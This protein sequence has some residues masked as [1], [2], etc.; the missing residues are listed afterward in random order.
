MARAILA[1]RDAGVEQLAQEPQQPVL[2]T[3]TSRWCS[4]GIE[5]RVPRNCE[6]RR[7]RSA[8]AGHRGR[9]P[10]QRT[11]RA[12]MKLGPP[13]ARARSTA[14]RHGLDGRRPRPCRRGSRRAPRTGRT[15]SVRRT[16]ASVDDGYSFAFWPSA[17]RR[18]VL[19]QEDRPGA[20]RI[21]AMLTDSC[22]AP[23][24]S[25]PSPNSADAHPV[26]PQLLERER[27]ADRDGER[28]AH[29]S[30]TWSGKPCAADARWSVPP[31]PR[32]V[33]VALPR[34]SA[35]IPA[36]ID[37][38][39]DEVA[40]V[41]VRGVGHVTLL[42]ERECRHPGRLLADVDVEMADVVIAVR[43]GSAPP[44]SGGS[45]A[46]CAAGRR[47]PRR[48]VGE[49][50][51]PPLRPCAGPVHGTG[52]GT[53][54]VCT[55]STMASRPGTKRAPAPG[56]T[57]GGA[58]GAPDP[59]DRRPKLAA[60]RFLDP[61]RDLARRS[62]PASTASWAIDQPAGP[63]RPTRRSCPC[64]AGC[65]LRRS[66]TSAVDA[67]RGERR[68]RRPAPWP[69]CATSARCVT[70]VPGAADR[71][72]PERHE[73]GVVA[74]EDF[75]AASST[76]RDARGTAPG[77]RNGSRPASRPWASAGVDGATTLS[78]GTCANHA[79]RLWLWCAPMRAARAALGADRSAAPTAARSSCSAAWRAWL[80]SWSMASV[81]KSMNMIS[82][83]GRR[84]ESAAPTAMP[85]D[86]GLADR[87]VP[88]AP[89]RSGRRG[90]W[91]PRTGPP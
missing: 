38:A 70:S 32:L 8:A 86:R 5:R 40:V 22:Q 62:R 31:L 39:R 54:R 52:A 33:P 87:R 81:M 17:S 18:V 74:V 78:P 79:S 63:G 73:R 51:R 46:S 28:P 82:T 91:W 29:D 80:T 34:I 76:G 6:A 67:L 60:C 45:G 15:R 69:P 24:S 21:A 64:R 11:V 53:R 66:M 90:P 3:P 65:R 89:A 2:R 1:G 16:A 36:R 4:S 88:D 9:L 50:L 37:A 43:G 23:S 47:A 59:D 13:P 84:P 83:I 44:R 72:A 26:E 30:T 61:R 85:D 19:A 14:R 42:Q 68:R 12:S 35:S 41:A 10:G 49:Q 27:G 20:L 75:T 25:A 57:G 7:R 48:Q 58:N 55:A 77:R 56:L 71:R